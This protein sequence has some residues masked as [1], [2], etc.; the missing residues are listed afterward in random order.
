MVNILP[1]SKI[2]TICATALC[3]M[4]ACGTM[5]LP[6]QTNSIHAASVKISATSAVLGVKETKT[7]KV[8]GTSTKVQWTSSNQKVATVSTS[9]KITGVGKGTATITATIGSTKKTCKVTVEKPSISKKSATLAA[10]SKLT[11]KM[12]GTTRTAKWSTSDKSIATVSSKGVVTGKKAGTVTITAKVGSTEYTSKVKVTM[13]KISATKS[14]MNKGDTMLLSVSGTKETVEWSSSDESVATVDSLGN[15]TGLSTGRATITAKIGSLTKKCTVTVTETMYSLYSTKFVTV[16]K[17]YTL[18]VPK[19]ATITVTGNL[20][21]TYSLDGEKLTIYPTEGTKGLVTATTNTAKY[22]YNLIVDPGTVNQTAMDKNVGLSVGSSYTLT[23]IVNGAI[24]TE[25]SNDGVISWSTS[26]KGLVI[27]GEKA[28]TA[29]LE[30]VS[31]FSTIHV[32][33][34][35]Q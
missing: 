28:G 2:G 29:Q 23:G 31:G 4:L 7:L 20:Q 11:L 12:S 1:K 14:S 33:V 18:D 30:I 22:E 35:V 19:N 17:S 8:T 15:V 3:A 34:T 32:T 16:G 9:G 24:L 25:T 26:D 5:A 27:K 10:G 13:P 6:M 21:M